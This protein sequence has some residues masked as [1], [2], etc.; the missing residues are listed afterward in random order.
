ML[1]RR[2][3]KLITAGDLITMIILYLLYLLSV[4][5]FAFLLVLSALLL[6][7]FPLTKGD[8]LLAFFTTAKWR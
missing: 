8:N 4:R 5:F 2:A 6:D 3:D 1:S 7:L